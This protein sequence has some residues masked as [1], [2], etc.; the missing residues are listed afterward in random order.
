MRKRMVQGALILA[1]VA[2]ITGWSF[3]ATD[4]R[5]GFSFNG[6]MININGGDFNQAIRDA[7]TW[8]ADYND[9]WDGDWYTANWNELK[10]MP[11]FGGEFMVRIGKYFGLGLGV[12]YLSKSNL[13][14]IDYVSEDSWNQDWFGIGYIVY[15]N[16]S[17][18]TDTYDQK[19]TVIPITLSFYGFL[20]VGPQ[21]EAYVKAGAGYYLGKLTTNYSDAWS[22]VYN[23]NWYWNSG[24]PWPPHYHDVGDYEYSET[25]EA[26]CNTLGFHFGAGFN[27]NVTPSI[28]L[29][30]EA[31]Y[32]L[33]NF[34]DWQGSGTWD[35][36][37]QEG[38]GD[39]AY[40]NTDNLPNHSTYSD[41]GTYGAGSK[42]WSYED[43][44]DSF[45][46]GSYLEY[47]AYE[48]GDEPEEDDWTKNVRPT[49]INLNGFSFKVGIRIFFGG[50]R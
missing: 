35:L 27:F 44:W 12:E 6:G 48:S 10:W 8:V 5:F 46:Q 1:L 29:F 19:L 16:N 45:D 26:T 13:G 9:Y 40:T 31:F 25:F 22:W 41:D 49:E 20:P 28:A 3:G 43:Q 34:N 4:L 7:N 21:A 11:N 2:G 37:G 14:T 23:E 32:R 50:I 24:T 42:L 30:G 18:S 36:Y 15:D 17:Y 47:W 33:A 39:T 38:W